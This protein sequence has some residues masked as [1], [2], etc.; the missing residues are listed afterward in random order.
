MVNI[1]VNGR[2]YT[3]RDFISVAARNRAKA[4]GRAA[5][6][7]AVFVDAVI[8]EALLDS[9]GNAFTDNDALLESVAMVDAYELY[10]AIMRMNGVAFGADSSPLAQTSDSATG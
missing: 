10:K 6:D 5:D 4:V 8:A 2:K 1:E 7:D 9:G 3:V